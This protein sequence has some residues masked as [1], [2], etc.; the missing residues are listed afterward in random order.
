MDTNPRFI[1]SLTVRVDDPE[2]IFNAA[3]AKHRDVDPQTAR[4]DFED[5]EGRIDV[6]ACLAYLYDPGESAPGSELEEVECE[7]G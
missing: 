7:E 3:V 1:V 4:E 5:D 2:A 6:A